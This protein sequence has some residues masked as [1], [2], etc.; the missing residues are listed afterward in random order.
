MKVGDLVKWNM[1]V[2]VGEVGIIVKV[3]E[4][5]N[6]V[7]VG[8]VHVQWPDGKKTKNWYKEIEVI[9]ESG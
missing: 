9:N 8:M 1:G 4:P 2:G 7:A 5:Q 6:L 3:A